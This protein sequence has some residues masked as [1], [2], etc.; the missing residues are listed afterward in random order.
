MTPLAELVWV[1]L[2]F[3][4][5]SSSLLLVNKLV[6]LVLPLPSFVAAA[7]FLSAAAFVLL[8]HA[9]G[10]AKVDALEWARVRPYLAY[11]LFFVAAVYSNMQA[12]RSSNVETL[13][14]CRACCP[15]LVAALEMA[16]LGRAAPCARSTLVLLS[17]VGGAAGYVASDRAFA[18]GG[19]SAY[20]W[21]VAYYGVICCSDTY[22]KSI[23]NLGWRTVWGPALYT[24]LLSAPPMV[25]AAYAT[26]EL[27][28]LRDV[29]WSGATLGALSLSC[30]LSVGISYTGWSCRGR[31]SATSYSVIGVVNKLLTVLGN[32]LLWDHE[33]ATPVGL[34][35]LLFCLL[36]ASQYRQAP[37]RP[38][39]QARRAS[40]AMAAA[41]KREE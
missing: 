30:V 41:R 35:C 5:C 29:E 3:S 4:V 28:R 14:I 12:L 7:Q 6:L 2:S 8:I 31:V 24:N 1:V 32:A 16:F 34:A 37:L 26:G 17:L 22:G 18:L 33:R 20:G 9:S 39:A 11:V 25:A 36:A 21:V 10:A 23:S 19:V 40:E 38:D 13:I 15:L 27:S